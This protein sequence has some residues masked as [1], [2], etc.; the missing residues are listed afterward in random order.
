MNTPAGGTAGA[1]TTLARGAKAQFFPTS[2]GNQPADPDAVL[3]VKSGVIVDYAI[4][5]PTIPVS[6]YAGPGQWTTNALNAQHFAKLAQAKK[7]ARN[8]N[9]SGVSIKNAPTQ[10]DMDALATQLQTTRLAQTK[11]N[12]D[13]RAAKEA[14]KAKRLKG[15]NTPVG[16]PGS[17]GMPAP[18]RS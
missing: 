18:Y 5:R 8:L 9:V 15:G 16:A 10:A 1:P 7:V 14:R 3:T 17:F 12:T 6:Y 11:R 4:T 13:R 2:G